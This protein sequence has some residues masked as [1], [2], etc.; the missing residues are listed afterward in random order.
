M[1]AELIQKFLR[2][3]QVVRAPASALATFGATQIE[4]HLI[5]PASDLGHRTRLRQG[6]VISEKPKI[7]T[8]DSFVERFEGFGPQA[9]EFAQW[10]GS[11]YGDILR[12]LEY[13]FKNQGFATR[14]ISE[15]P[16]KVAQRITADLEGRDARNQAVI[17][18]P[19]GA[20]SLALMKLTLDESKRSFATHVRDLDRRGLFDGAAK[21]QDRRRREISELFAAAAQDRSVLDLLGQKLREYDL[22]HEYEDRYLSFF[23]S[24]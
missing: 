23:Q 16:A 6:K 24:R 13:N 8:P 20:W 18:C 22:F 15:A 9:K 19:D 7:L 21:A 17:R 12:A 4:Y 3:T 14:V 11:R 5:S 2:Q 10:I 1:D